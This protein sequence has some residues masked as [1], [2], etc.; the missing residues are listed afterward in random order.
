[1]KKSHF[2][3]ISIFAICL[4]LTTISGVK[5]ASAFQQPSAASTSFYVAPSW[6]TGD[7]ALTAGAATAAGTSG[8]VILDFGRQQYDTSLGWGVWPQ[9]TKY[10]ISDAEVNTI[11]QNFI[12]GYNSQESASPINLTVATSNDDY[13]NQGDSKWATA[14]NDWGILVWSITAPDN[15]MITGGNDIETWTD[16]TFQTYGA[17]TIAWC[18]AYNL[19]NNNT[20]LNFGEQ[21][22]AIEPTAW[23]QAQVYEVSWLLGDD[24]CMPEI[25]YDN[26]KPTQA[27]EWADIYNYSKGGQYFLGTTSEHGYDNSISW[28]VA[29]QDLQYAILHSSY[30]NANYV[31]PSATNF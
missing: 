16:G 25:Y 7:T 13:W 31:G 23:S 22:A 27:S 1:M 4:F 6:T 17:D 3:S 28:D 5:N 2:L 11:V 24:Y 10:F 21:C 19:V 8:N 26:T 14:G 20:M 9:G 29:W 15:I 12:K 18:T 30:P